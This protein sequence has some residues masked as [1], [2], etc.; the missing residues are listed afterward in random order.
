MQPSKSP[1]MAPEEAR[2]LFLNVLK[3]FG[4]LLDF[5]VIDSDEPASFIWGKVMLP[6]WYLREPKDE[7]LQV[8]RHEVGHRAIFPGKPD[9]EKLAALLARRRGVTDVE[10]FVNVVADWLVDYE[11]LKKYG[12][13]Y[14]ARIA[15]Q[16]KRY[17]GRDPRF[18]ILAAVYQ[19]MAEEL[20]IKS[21]DA[22]SKARRLCRD[23]EEVVETAKEAYKVLRSSTSLEGKIERLAELLKEYFHALMKRAFEEKPRKYGRRGLPAMRK[24]S[25]FIPLPILLTQDDKRNPVREPH[26]LARQMAL[27]LRGEEVERLVENSALPRRGQAPAFLLKLGIGY[28]GEVRFASD[29]AVVEAAR[30]SLYS[31]YVEALERVGASGA[32][33]EELE[34]WTLG[35]LPHELRVEETLRVYGEVLPPVFSLKF[36]EREEPESGGRGGSV[37][38]ILDCSDSMGIAMRTAKQAAF[39]ILQE[40][41]KR[42]DEVYLIFFS[43]NAV[44]L[45][46]GRDYDAYEKAV[47]AVTYYG[48]TRLP[49]ALSHA[50]EY[51]E[52]VGRATTFI[53]SDAGTTEVGRAVEMVR[54]LLKH[55]K[56]VFFWIEG[57]GEYAEQWLRESGAKVYIVPYDADFTEDALREAMW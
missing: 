48:G 19:L 45:P 54:E 9:W 39:S 6:K 40:A 31:R 41:R 37:I 8:L 23:G 42:G 50:L 34:Q 20:G 32:K 7:V 26:W 29:D 53:I 28:T 55:G 47:A 43:G 30:L 16:I 18:W 27:H 38:V 36:S 12:E 13:E 21:P 14:Y 25:P 5:E 49:R 22:I 3:E 46:P 33:V 1:G 4:V 2:R 44:P 11:L 51:A 17:G 57:Y 56:V 52:K 35:D 10:T 24:A 15:K